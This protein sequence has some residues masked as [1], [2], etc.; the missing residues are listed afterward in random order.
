MG[1]NYHNHQQTV[2]E[3][4]KVF[5]QK[6]GCS[7]LS[8]SKLTNVP[9]PAIDQ[10][11]LQGGDCLDVSAYNAYILQINQRFNFAEGDLLKLTPEPNL[12]PPPPPAQIERSALAQEAL[13]GLD[14]I[15]TIYSRYKVK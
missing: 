12:L 1:V 9:R 15:L 3:N 5:M 2:A 8:L 7:R 13:D 14:Q 10:L 6:K 4:L 11:L